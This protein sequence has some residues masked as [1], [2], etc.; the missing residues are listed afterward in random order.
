MA[1][2]IDIP[3]FDMARVTFED[4]VKAWPTL[5]AQVLA[6]GMNCTGCVLHFTILEFL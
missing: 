1:R 6:S 4:M 2:D 3:D 5:A